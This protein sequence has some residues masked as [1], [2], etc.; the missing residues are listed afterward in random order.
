MPHLNGLLLSERIIALN[1]KM[2][3]IMCTGFSED[4]TMEE[5]GKIGIKAL[6]FKPIIKKELAQTIRNILD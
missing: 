2:P 5:A 1:P 4:I 6:L 3:I